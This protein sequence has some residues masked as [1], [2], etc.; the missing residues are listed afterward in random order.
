M[1]I[2]NMGPESRKLQLR[3]G[4]GAGETGGI[5]AVAALT[6][7]VFVRHTESSRPLTIPQLIVDL[8][9]VCE[10]MGWTFSE[11]RAVLGTCLAVGTLCL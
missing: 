7:S 8:L 11:D 4:A 3:A 5:P 10:L 2:I 1:M 6:L 9:G